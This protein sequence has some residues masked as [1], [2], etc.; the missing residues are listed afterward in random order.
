MPREDEGR[1]RRRGEFAGAIAK[2]N[3][4]RIVVLVHHGKILMAVTVE[5]ACGNRR[6]IGAGRNG[7]GL[8][9]CAVTIAEEHVHLVRG[10]IADNQI[11][12]SAIRE[13]RGGDSR[14]RGR[15]CCP[16]NSQ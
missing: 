12:A 13:C 9:K 8:L 3:R 14:M 15:G 1:T 5:V 16:C 11:V 2:K 4:N 6:G 10:R 7:H